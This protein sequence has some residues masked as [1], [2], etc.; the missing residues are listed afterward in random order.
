VKHLD[1]GPAFEN[2]G[3]E[4]KVQIRRRVEN[5]S[6]FGCVNLDQAE[7]FP[8]IPEGIVFRI[9][10]QDRRFSQV[11]G[12]NPDR[13]GRIHQKPVRVHERLLNRNGC[14]MP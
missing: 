3:Q 9:N 1:D 12:R 4:G 14:F 5:V 13:L 2:S 10:P 11:I 8:E 6:G 7:L